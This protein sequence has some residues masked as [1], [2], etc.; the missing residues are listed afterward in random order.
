MNG[1]VW[2]APK[3]DLLA[4][5]IMDGVRERARLVKELLDVRARQAGRGYM[6]VGADGNGQH[7][8]LVM[9]VALACW[10][11]RTRKIGHQGRVGGMAPRVV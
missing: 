7:D 1:R 9:A 11:G 6:R 8:D 10:M 2:L 5:R 3:I 4:L